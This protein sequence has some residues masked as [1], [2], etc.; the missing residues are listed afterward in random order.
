MRQLIGDSSI[1]RVPFDLQDPVNTPDGL[2]IENADVA[3]KLVG[4]IE[5]AQTKLAASQIALDAQLGDIQYTQRNDRKIPIPG[6]EG[7]A[8]AYSMIVTQ[9]SKEPGVGYSP[10]IHGNSIVQFTTWDDEGKV[11]PRGLLTYS[12]SQE[13]DSPHYA[14]QTELYS[15]GEW[16]DFPFYDEEI[17][18]DPNLRTLQLSE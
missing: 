14:D 5:N 9:L 8:G 18:T 2:N 4:A 15:R 7:W 13:P 11:V 3:A 1:Y 12:Q 17:E 16:I 6:G 10:I